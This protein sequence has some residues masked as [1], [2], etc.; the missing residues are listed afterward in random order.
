MT[1]RVLADASELVIVPVSADSDD[2]VRLLAEYYAELGE[3][4]PHGFD[5]ARDAGASPRELVPPRG[6]FLLVR[7]QGR[8]VSCGTVRKVSNGVAEIKRIWIDPAARGHGIGRLLLT[9]LENTARGLT[10]DVVRLDT[11][12]HLTEALALYRSAGYSEVPAFN[13]N[14]HAA[15]WLQKRLPSL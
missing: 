14:P 11:S 4:F 13:T 3:R 6:A 8:P 9:T 12:A 1:G 10:C 15:H 2:A 5:L 7:R